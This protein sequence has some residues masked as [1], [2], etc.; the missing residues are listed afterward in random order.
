[1]FVPGIRVF[2]HVPTGDNE[3]TLNPAFVVDATQTSAVIRLNEPTSIAVGATVFVHWEIQCKFRQQAAEVSAILEIE[4]AVMLVLSMCGEIQPADRRRAYRVM[5]MPG[6][7]VWATLDNHI[8]RCHVHDL[9]ATGLSLETD[10]A[11]RVGA[12]VMLTVHHGPNH[13]R[14]TMRVQ[15]VRSGVDGQNRFGLEAV[16][17]R[18]G[19]VHEELSQG[20]GCISG[21]LQRVQARSLAG[22]QSLGLSSVETSARSLEYRVCAWAARSERE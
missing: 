11:L 1:M 20:L 10:A 16:E 4:P 15:G 12:T 3:H 18:Y 7:R 9:S 17:P 13:Y 8:E 14:G 21:A 6:S 5:I 19:G 22:Q 2:V